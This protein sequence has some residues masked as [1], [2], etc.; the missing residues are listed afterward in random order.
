MFGNTNQPV[1]V[2]VQTGHLF[3]PMP[4]IIRDDMAFIDRMHFYLP[5]WEI[6]KMQNDFFTS[7]YGF[8]VDYLAEAL[9][10][11][12]RHNYTEI[13]DRH[14]SLG[15]HLNARDRK[16]VRKTVSGLVKILY[17]HG[18]ISRDDL[19]ELLELA[20]EGRRRVKEQ[21]KKMGSF[22]YYHTSFSYMVEDTGEERFVGVPE[23]GGRD[24]IS[25]DPLAPGTVYSAGVTSDGT[26]GLYRMEVSVSTGTGKLKLAGGV[27]GATRESVQRAFSFVQA[28][29]GELGIARD[30]DVSDLHVEVIDLLG[31]RVEAELGVAFFV[32]AYSALRKA[33][34]APAL[35]IL[36]DM[37]VQG[38]IKPLRS[39]TEPLQVAKDN[40]AK[41]ALIP[42]ENKRTFLEVNADIVEHVD[43]IFFG[44]PKVAATKALGL[45]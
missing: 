11:M 20:L 29:K 30:M 44:D 3:S 34:V 39:L 40:G 33:P 6:P 27:S 4:D 37:S 24:L 38:N 45:T 17:P 12:R 15:A 9:R 2:M 23:Q 32:A 21:L 1:D 19:V 16:A 13:S 8:V 10:E 26:V 25:T 42:I 7:H 43:P 18:D 22:E 41:R 5:G 14:F 35:L 36:G 31:N 28:K